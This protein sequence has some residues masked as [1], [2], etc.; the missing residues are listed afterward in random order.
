M[1]LIGGGRP[2]KLEKILVS[3]SLSTTNLTWTDLGT[4]QRPYRKRLTTNRLIHDTA[5]KDENLRV[6]KYSVLTTL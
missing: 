4:N 1:M 3:A 5:L 6:S 2:K